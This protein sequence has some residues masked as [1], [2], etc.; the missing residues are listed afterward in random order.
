MKIKEVEQTLG[1]DRAN[2][3]YYEREGLLLPTRNENHYRNYSEEDIARLKTV[4]ILRKLGVS[5]AEI[6]EIL[7]GR[8]SMTDAL[9]ENEE[10]LKK[11]LEELNGA[12]SLCR[13]MKKEQVELDTFDQDY[14]WEEIHREEQTGNRFL[15]ICKDYLNFEK[16]VFYQTFWDIEDMSR[17]CGWTGW[18]AVVYPLAM[19]LAV[20]VAVGLEA[21]LLGDSFMEG[22]LMPLNIFLFASIIALPEFLLR[23]KYPKA[24]GMWRKG[25]AALAIAASIL[26][27]LW[28]AVTLLNDKFHFLF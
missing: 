5:V 17:E 28:L 1:V 22:F 12:L 16:G 11:Q 7:E 21:L 27:L 24:A 20:L 4:V 13:R 19:I 10:N 18:K 15:D 6:R 25:I 9:A 23:K 26:I 2:I 3:R 8:Q 14:Y